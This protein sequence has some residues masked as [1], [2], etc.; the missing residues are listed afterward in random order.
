MVCESDGSIMRVW[1]KF[2]GAHMSEM[3]CCDD[4]DEVKGRCHE[5]V[6]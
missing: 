4:S 3:K 6:K 5:V 1:P 2:V